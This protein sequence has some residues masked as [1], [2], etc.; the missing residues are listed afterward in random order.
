MRFTLD[1]VGRLTWH[2]DLQGRPIYPEGF[3]ELAQKLNKP[4]DPPGREVRCIVSV[5]MLTEGWD[6]NTVTHIIGLRP[7]MSQLL[8][9][10]VVGR[11]LR[12]AKYELTEDGRFSEEVAKV[13]GV[14]FEV[15][16][17]K[18]DPKGG[19]PK[20]EKRYHVYAVPSKTQFEI[21]FP[22]VE[23]YTR[24]IRNRVTVDWSVLPTLRLIPGTIP[25]E[26]DM[27]GGLPNNKGRFSLTG[28]GAIENVSLNP[29]RKGRRLQELIFD[30]AAAL[31]RDYKAQPRCAVPPQVLFPQM[32][33]IVDRYL[34]QYVD[35][36]PPADILDVFLSPYYGLVV[37][38]LLEAIRP[39]T[40]K[41]EAPE[42]PRYEA[43][44][45]PGT[46]AEVDFW[47]SREPREV[48]HS[49]LNYMVPDTKRW[50]QSTAYY[51]DNHPATA[52]FVKNAGLGFSIPYL[53]NGQ[54]HDYIPDFIVKLKTTPIAHVIVET[55][56]YDPLTEV[57]KE[58][59]ERWAA[60]V[61]AD[62]TYG[63]W[64]YGLAR[65]PEEVAGLLTSALKG[66]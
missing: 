30:M 11:G 49:H 63:K 53:H 15:I 58:A 47:T 5:G 32:A 22:R 64:M 13:F 29:Y 31:T 12:R 33:K 59:A 65:K 7:F 26:V 28:P 17:Y 50:E 40:S 10:Q 21:R 46:T 55:K 60:A 36:V 51:I 37:E 16:P 66:K 14:P 24:A 61:N 38:R 44:R 9:E 4:L 41:G 35:A 1:T 2:S 19:A 56:G 8:C 52:A 62:G 3:E 43:N 39:D 20:K 54:M 23:G 45:G 34:R 6:C 18:S 27:K 57:K 42:V 48:V 25:P